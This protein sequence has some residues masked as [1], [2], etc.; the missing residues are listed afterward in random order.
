MRRARVGAE[1]ARRTSFASPASEPPLYRPRIR[2]GRERGPPAAAAAPA[3]RSSRTA[4]ATRRPAARLR[5]PRAIGR[6]RGGRLE[7]R[8]R[9][10]AGRLR[11]RSGSPPR[12][13]TTTGLPAPPAAARTGSAT[14]ARPAAWR[15]GRSRSVPGSAPSAL[16]RREHHRA[17]DPLVEIAAADAD[18]LRDARAE[19]ID[20]AAHL[21][22]AGPGR[23]DQAD[24]A[25]AGR[26]WRSP[27]GT[28]SRI[29]VPQSGPI[30][31]GPC[32]PA[33]A[34][35]SISSSTGDVV[36]EQED[37]AGRA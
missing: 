25:R 8:R 13:L 5:R 10:R 18:R 23:A 19:P 14:D 11:S 12:K 2:P 27:S 3:A 36:A 4:S 34:L 16:E 15:S 28:P 29:A 31:A 7:R 17:A 9:D 33:S 30:T 32:A 24:R 22:Q 20:Q 37:V 26:R 1:R 6:D 35:S 21:L